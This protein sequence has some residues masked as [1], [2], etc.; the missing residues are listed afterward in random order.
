MVILDWQVSIRPFKLLFGLLT[1]AIA[2]VLL[3]APKPVA[4]AVLDPGPEVF[5]RANAI[6]TIDSI[7][8]KR[9][10]NYD[11]SRRVQLATVVVDE[12]I[13]NGFDPLFI[14]AV[15]E[16]ESGY[17]PEALSPTGAR[18]LMQI[19]PSTWTE[20]AKRLN[21]PLTEKFN[22]VHNATI[23]IGY[24]AYLAKTFHRPE[25]VLLAYNQGASTALNVL[26]KGEVPTQEGAHYAPAVMDNYRKLLASMKLDPNKTR[27]YWRSPQLTVMKKPTGYSDG[28][29]K[30]LPWD[31]EK[32]CQSWS[33]PKPLLIRVSKPNIVAIYHAEG[34]S[35]APIRFFAE[36][37]RERQLLFL[38]RRYYHDRRGLSGYL[39]PVARYFGRARLEADWSSILPGSHVSFGG[40]PQGPRYGLDR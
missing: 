32:L 31:S 3:L 23:G 10:D 38:Q 35:N 14:L 9:M 21:T 19:I 5:I 7:L 6:R 37:C 16:V 36:R 26:S 17:D 33:D 20:Q 40:D 34:L 28:G 1:T 30:A 13:S 8:A 18:G 2:T 39:L 29:K 4:T 27:L 25:S 11:A 15:I 24:L 12:S 22:P